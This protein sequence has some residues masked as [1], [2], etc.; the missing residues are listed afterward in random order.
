ME[1]EPPVESQTQTTVASEQPQ[2]LE[3]RI[4]RGVAWIAVGFGSRQIISWLSMLALVR[5]LEPRAFGVVAL[6][7]AAVSASE[8]LR[9]AGI[10]AALVF[11]RSRIEEAAASA[12]VYLAFSSL[13]AYGICFAAAPLLAS[14]FHASDLTSVLRVLAVLMIFSG[15]NVVPTAILERDLSYASVARIDLAAVAAQVV[16]SISL[17]VAGAGV[18]S[19]VGGQVAAGAFE[20]LSVWYLVPWR[21]SPR[22]ASWSMLRELFGYARFAGI[23]SIATFVKGMMDT[24][25]VGRILGSVAVGYYSVAFRLATTPDSLF[26]YIILKAMFPAF[27]SIQHDLGAFRRTF[28]QH[29]QRMVLLVL[30]VSIFLALAAEPVVLTL[31]GE[32]WSAIVTPVRILAISGFVSAVSATTS[33]AF[34]GAGRPELA[35]WFVGANALLLLPALI[36]FVRWLELNGAAIAVLGC[37]TATTVPALIRTMRLLELPLRDLLVMLRP[38]LACAGVLALALALLIPALSTADS[39]VS[40]LVL[41]A[42][43]IAT[44][45]TSTA[46][47]ARHVVV[48]MWLD[49]RGRVHSRG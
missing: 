31:L 22:L 20:L 35:M 17:A 12:L 19:L 1:P 32:K 42:A 30:P 9:G 25:V 27:S 45:F 44:Y 43:G 5:L 28:L 29:T 34:R 21:P 46:I 24:I 47:F 26:S 48:P 49:L 11:R 3:T 15:L 18:W 6:A 36:V 13:A 41:L 33:A 39:L 8:Y 7:Y 14:A 4:L 37:L 23:W 38:A 2:S 10:W 16:V 40:L